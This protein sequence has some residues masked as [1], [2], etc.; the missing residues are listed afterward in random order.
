MND[1]PARLIN[2]AERANKG[3]GEVRGWGDGEGGMGQGEREDLAE[4]KR[5][6]AGTSPE[7]HPQAVAAATSH[8][9]TFF[10]DRGLVHVPELLVDIQCQPRG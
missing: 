10:S 7:R 9:L 6:A 4:S 5:K 8:A 3:D 1:E 2:E